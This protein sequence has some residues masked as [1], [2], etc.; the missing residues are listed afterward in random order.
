MSA[1]AGSDALLARAFRRFERAATSLEERHRALRAKADQLERQLLDAHRR[2]EAVLDALD[3]GI[4]VLS[5]DGTVVRT[6]RALARLGWI[7]GD[8][9]LKKPVLAAFAAGAP[10]HGGTARIRQE[11]D[12]GVRD[13]AVT[14]VPVGDADGTRVLT[15]QDVTE[16]RREEEEGGRRQRLEALGTMAAEIAHEVRNPLGSIRLFAGMLRDDL[17]G[18]DSA[19]EMADQILAATA[20]LEATVSNLLA[21]A[22]P[23]RSGKRPM[24][25]AAL[26]S[27]VSSLFAPSCALRGVTLEGPERT[28]ACSVTADPEGM[29]QLLLNLLGN[30][31]AATGEGGRILVGARLEPGLALLEVKDTGRG[32]A[33]EDLPRVFDPFFSRTEGGTGLGLSIVHRIVERHGGRIAMDSRLGAGTCVRVEI[34]R[35]GCDGAAPEE[36]HA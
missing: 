15:V 20:G 2:L 32:I 1:Q 11:I 17:A 8:G 23:S 4:A 25:L 12:G 13:L 6:N 5:S 27:D 29:R 24:D 3:G 30:A 7:D 21:F 16:I 18:R 28:A 34:P 19:R 33:L 9:E 10:D 26:A 14:L 31:L 35:E 36:P 22:S